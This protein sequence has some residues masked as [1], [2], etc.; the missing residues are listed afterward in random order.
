[1]KPFCIASALLIYFLFST[2]S[3]DAK[4]ADNGEA[5][6]R[7]RTIETPCVALSTRPVQPRL[8]TIM[9]C[10]K[11]HLST[12]DVDEHAKLSVDVLLENTGHTLLFYRDTAT[13][14]GIHGTIEPYR[15]KTDLP[16]ER[17]TMEILKAVK[18]DRVGIAALVIHTS[19]AAAVYKVHEVLADD[20]RTLQ[21]RGTL[22]TRLT[23]SEM[24]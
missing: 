10:S 13:P 4:P 11:H 12:D 17:L 9:I 6:I 24:K 21:F 7:P 8:A 18:N 1:V 19:G 3:P 16:L 23:A 22:S 15:L 20:E 2:E 14:E 5:I